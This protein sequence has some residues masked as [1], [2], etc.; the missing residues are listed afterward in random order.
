M[1]EMNLDELSQITGGIDSNSEESGIDGTVTEQLP[2]GMF[3]VQLDTGETV[4]VYISG[5][6]R[7]NYIRIVCGDRVTVELNPTGSADGRIIWKYKR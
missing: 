4:K 7:M 5:K 1:K 6:L 2:N 3:M